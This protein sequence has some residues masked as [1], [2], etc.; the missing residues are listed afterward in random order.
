QNPVVL[1]A[2]GWR[3][4]L[5]GG[6]VGIVTNRFP[7][8]VPRVVPLGFHL[9]A[10]ELVHVDSQGLAARSVGNDEAPVLSPCRDKT[11]RAGAR[12]QGEDGLVGNHFVP[13]SLLE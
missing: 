13:E 3:H 1:L 12:L 10:V 6:V 11:I 9:R 8:S 5:V 7:R 4:K 2:L